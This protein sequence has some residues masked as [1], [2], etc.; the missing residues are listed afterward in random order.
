[1]SS[2]PWNT[3]AIHWNL[4]KFISFVFYTHLGYKLYSDAESYEGSEIQNPTSGI[5]A[6]Q[7][8]A[9]KFELNQMSNKK[10]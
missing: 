4:L 1:M 6:M 2:K 10:D 7:K 8:E 5:V 3:S 9:P